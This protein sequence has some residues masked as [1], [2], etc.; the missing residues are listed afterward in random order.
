MNINHWYSISVPLG[1]TVQ[2]LTMKLG[3]KLRLVTYCSN[4]HFRTVF[5]TLCNV[6][7]L[8][9]SMEHSKMIMETNY[10]AGIIL[11]KEVISAM[12]S[13]GIDDGHIININR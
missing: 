7:I 9:E 2:Q 4:D 1:F 12:K 8:D 13:K 5:L 10:L 3:K 6:Y 11:T